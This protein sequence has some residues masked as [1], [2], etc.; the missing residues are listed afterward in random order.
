MEVATPTLSA[1]S[2]T[3]TD[4]LEVKQLREEVARLADLVTSLKTRSRR[5]S[6][7]RLRRPQT[8]SPQNPP[9]AE[10]SLCWYRAKYNEAAYRSARTRAVGGNA[11]AGR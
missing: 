7:S 6:T 8:P 9:P 1:I 11:Q 3:H 5:L 2:D 4:S 10:D